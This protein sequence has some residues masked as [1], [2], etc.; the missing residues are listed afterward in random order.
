MEIYT[1]ILC[2]NCVQKIVNNIL[3][4]DVILFGDLQYV[5]EAGTGIEPVYTDLQVLHTI[6]FIIKS[7]N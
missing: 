6:N 3:F 5:V 2:T 1:D 7:I 4:W